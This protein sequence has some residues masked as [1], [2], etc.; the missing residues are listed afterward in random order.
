MRKRRQDKVCSCSKT[1]ECGGSRAEAGTLSTVTTPDVRLHSH[2]DGLP[3][4]MGIVRFI[5]SPNRK[6][7]SAADGRWKWC[8]PSVWVD[9]VGERVQA[10]QG[11]PGIA[12]GPRLGSAPAQVGTVNHNPGVWRGTPLV[13]II[14]Q[15]LPW[16][17]FFLQFSPSAGCQQDSFL[18][19]TAVF[20]RTVAGAGCRPAGFFPRFLTLGTLFFF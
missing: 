13:C 3:W 19:L 2:S 15:G 4:C 14:P 1:D 18:V 10:A 12:H 9:M 20:R 8:R 17:T 16:G 11:S 6:S 5:P 7:L